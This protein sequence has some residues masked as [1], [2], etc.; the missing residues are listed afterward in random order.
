MEQY[1][2]SVKAELFDDQQSVVKIHCASDPVKRKRFG[3]KIQNYRQDKWKSE[4]ED[5]LQRFD[6]QV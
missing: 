2:M 5:S 3:Y 6:G 4:M 1:L